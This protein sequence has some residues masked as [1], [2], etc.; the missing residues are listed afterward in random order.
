MRII[1]AANPW[2]ANNWINLSKW[3][4]IIMIT[5]EKSRNTQAQNRPP[6][7]LTH[8]QSAISH[9]YDHRL[10]IASRVPSGHHTNAHKSFADSLTASQLVSPI[11]SPPLRLITRSDA[12]HPGRAV[13]QAQSVESARPV[14]CPTKVSR[15]SSRD[16]EWICCTNGMECVSLEVILRVRRRGRNGIG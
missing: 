1:N 14:S 2:S 4:G 6:S 12:I 13:T 8:F 7:P 16:G 11:G 9:N 10:L 15:I 3:A 5:R